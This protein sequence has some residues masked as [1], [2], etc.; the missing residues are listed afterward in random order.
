MTFLSAIQSDVAGA[1]AEDVRKTVAFLAAF[2]DELVSMQKQTLEALLKSSRSKQVKEWNAA[3]N[4]WQRKVQSLNAEQREVLDDWEFVLCDMSCL[5]PVAFLPRL[6]RCL[7]RS[8]S[9]LMQHAD[10]IKQLGCKT[11]QHV[12][13][14]RQVKQESMSAFIRLLLERYMEQFTAEQKELVLQWESDLCEKSREVEAGAASTEMTACSR[15]Q[16]FFAQYAHEIIL[17]EKASLREVVRSHQ[18]NQH[19]EWKYAKNF[20]DRYHQTLTVEQ[21]RMLDDWEFL[22]C[23]MSS[24]QPVAFLPRLQRCLDRS[25]SFLTQNADSI[26]QL[27][28]KTLQQVLQSRQMKEESMAVFIRLLL[29]RHTESNSQQS[30]RSLFCAGNPSCARGVEKFKLEQSQV[31]QRQ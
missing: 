16:C 30:S 13:R 5:Q 11:L 21:K 12:L 8:G 28:A 31:W 15:L 18:A 25:Q 27:G 9:F 6:Q 14:S 26:K 17:L 19:A 22:L 29:E 24:L 20:F 7:D 3:K 23:D 1:M 4:F 10:S 2:A